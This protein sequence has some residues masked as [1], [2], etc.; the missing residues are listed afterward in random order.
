MA[1]RPIEDDLARAAAA[2]A[3]AEAVALACH[4]VPDGDA[5][6]SMLALHHLCLANGKPSVASWPQPFVVAPH[7]RFLPGLDL[8]SDP[9][10]FPAAPEV[11]VTFDCG[12]ID[13]LGELGDSA[14]AAGELVVLDH[15]ASNNRFGTINVV[16]PAAAATAVVVRRVADVLGW[17]LNRE[18]ALCLYTGLVTDT[19]RFQYDNT[20]PAV[21]ALAEEL[22]GFDLPLASMTRQLFEEHRFTYLQLVGECL[23][24]AKLDTDARF[25]ATW[26]T[27]DDLARHGVEMDE[28]EGLID[29]VRRASEADVA[30]VAK[31]TPE[32]IRVS[33]RSVTELDVGVIA[34]QF[35]G[36]GHAYAA[37]FTVTGPVEKVVDDVRDAVVR[38][39]AARSA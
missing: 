35:G 31:E 37:G 6:G 9:E 33:L 21:F 24:R 1:T 17:A 26:I 4:V 18:A 19:G 20:T 15:H 11:M 36:G 3:G 7:Y 16:D 22:A 14:R 10:R 32:G 30:C 39:R 12:S 27:L 2:I 8:A 28:A 5:L 25:V 23:A 13:R 38:H 29:L 34:G